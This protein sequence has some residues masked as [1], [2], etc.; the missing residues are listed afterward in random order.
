MESGLLE[1]IENAVA[2]L[3]AVECR[4]E[5]HGRF[6]SAEEQ[7][8]MRRHHLTDFLQNEF[9]G[10][11]REVDQPAISP[12]DNPFGSTPME[13]SLQRAIRFSGKHSTAGIDMTGP[14]GSI[15]C[16]GGTCILEQGSG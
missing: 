13:P 12:M 8:G 2:V 15:K 5:S 3:N 4:V 7:R 9:F 14:Q 6:R 16:G 1:A 11:R 10:F